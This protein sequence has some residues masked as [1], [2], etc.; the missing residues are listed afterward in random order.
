M[1][2]EVARHDI[3][4][5]LPRAGAARRRARARTSPITASPTTSGTAR[6]GAWA[7]ST[8]WRR[9]AAFLVSDD[10]RTHGRRSH[11]WR[12]LSD[13]ARDRHRRLGRARTRSGEGAR[14]SRCARRRDVQERRGRRNSLSKAE[15][16]GGR[17]HRGGARRP[18]DRARRRG[19]SASCARRPPTAG[20]DRA[21]SLPHRGRARCGPGRCPHPSPRSPR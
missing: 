2:K 14:R 6:S 4:V 20:S 1:A 21:R 13:E 18:R 16:P 11:G 3:R 5:Q 12:S 7:R 8:R 15:S 10:A 19:R 9:F 17:L